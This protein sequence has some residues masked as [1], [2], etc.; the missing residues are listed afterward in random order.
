M[1]QAHKNVIKWIIYVV[2]LLLFYTLQTTPGLFQIMGVKPVLIVPFALCIAI[3]E[4][5][6]AGAFIGILTGLLW[7]VSSDRLFGYNGLIMMIACATVALLIMYLMRANW[8]NAALLCGG[9]MLAQQMLD[10]LFYYAMWGY[11]GVLQILLQVTLPTVVYTTLLSPLMFLL[12]RKIASK[13]NEVV[14]V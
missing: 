11:A 14:R 7:D 9:V 13:F 3:F 1:K 2:L 10:F 5:E 4:G 8:L 12:V 6:W